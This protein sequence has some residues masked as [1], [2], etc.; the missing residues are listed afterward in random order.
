MIDVVVNKEG[1][2]S[3]VHEDPRLEGVVK[4][5]FHD[6]TN[7]LY[8]IYSDGRKLYLGRLSDYLKELFKGQD[9]YIVRMNGWAI[10]ETRRLPVTIVS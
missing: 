4:V 10:Q 9:G 6:A 7:D 8:V 3:I 2:L 1:M 5:E